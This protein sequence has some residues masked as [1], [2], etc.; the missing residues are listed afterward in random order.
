[1]IKTNTEFATQKDAETWVAK[2]VPMNKEVYIVFPTSGEQYQNYLDYVDT[3]E[4]FLEIEFSISGIPA[5]AL[6]KI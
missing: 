5:I 1:M 4:N 2:E 6:I 3:N